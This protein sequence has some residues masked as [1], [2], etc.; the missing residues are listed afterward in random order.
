MKIID[1]FTN[2]FNS[3]ELDSKLNIPDI[4]N[5]FDYEFSIS[6]NNTVFSV[7]TQSDGKILI[8]GQFSTVGGITRNRIA[9]LNSDGT[10]DTGFNPNANDTVRINS[11]PTRR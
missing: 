5:F 2:E 7:A 6:T 10:L 11:H 3:I 8:G 9:R 4:S 1:L